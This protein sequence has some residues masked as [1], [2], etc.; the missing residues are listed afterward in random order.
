MQLAVTKHKCSYPPSAM[1][2][3]PSDSS[4][5]LETC[6]G[7]YQD[8]VSQ[9]RFPRKGKSLYALCA[10]EK[11]ALSLQQWRNSRIPLGVWLD[12]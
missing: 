1:S 7:K 8:V 2:L 4:E 11:M 3:I 10:C 5:R 9:H 12:R 6:E